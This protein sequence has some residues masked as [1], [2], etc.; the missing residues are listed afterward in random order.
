MCVC[1]CVSVFEVNRYPP[2][3][4]SVQ[5][6]LSVLSMYPTSGLAH[7]ST[8]VFFTGRHFK[9]ITS[10]MCRLGAAGNLVTPVWVESNMVRV[11]MP[12]VCMCVCVY[13]CMCVCVCVCAWFPNVGRVSCAGVDQ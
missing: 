11:P 2:L 4:V 8:L 1:V 7:G 9:N 6:T 10:M 5:P 13:V 12:C 3:Y